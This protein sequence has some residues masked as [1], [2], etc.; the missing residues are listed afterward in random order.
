MCLAPVQMLDGLAALQRGGIERS[1]LAKRNPWKWR[2]QGLLVWGEKFEHGDVGAI[3]F[4][5][6]FRSFVG[7][8]GVKMGK[9]YHRDCRC[10]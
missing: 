4:Y 6:A 10:A 1:V 9:E 5:L 3:H 7:E 8:H 2:V